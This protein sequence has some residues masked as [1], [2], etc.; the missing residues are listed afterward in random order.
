MEHKM[1]AF[2]SMLH[3]VFIFPSR[4]NLKKGVAY[5]KETAGL[6]RYTKTIIDGLLSKHLFKRKIK[7]LTTLSYLLTYVALKPIFG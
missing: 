6:N 5:I 4:E 3:H 2:H 1:A 7:E